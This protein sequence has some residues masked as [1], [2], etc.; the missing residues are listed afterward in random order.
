MAATPYNHL[1][2][3]GPSRTAL[4]V[5]I[6]VALAAAWMVSPIG[7]SAVVVVVGLLAIAGAVVLRAARAVP[8]DPP[9]VVTRSQA[10]EDRIRVAVQQGMRD[11]DRYL[12][13]HA[14]FAAYLEQRNTGHDTAGD[15]DRHG[16]LHA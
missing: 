2:A 8:D 16:Q 6:G 12:E 15:D 13:A 5:G 4:L 14:A 1:R 10:T 9:A 3:T 7:R 11:L